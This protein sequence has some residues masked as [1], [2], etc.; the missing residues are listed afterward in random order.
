MGE[1]AVTG[2]RLELNGQ[3]MDAGY[4]E[5]LDLTRGMSGQMPGLA[6]YLADGGKR[7]YSVS[8]H[9][10]GDIL[11]KL[12]DLETATA[13]DAEMATASNA[14]SGYSVATGSNLATGSDAEKP[15]AGSSDFRL[16][17]QSRV[18]HGR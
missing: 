18:C 5:D 10:D 11:L 4:Q 15:R 8:Y 3:G 12:E 17:T 2:Y 14:E 7:L 9:V 13:S 6:E 16:H 1:T